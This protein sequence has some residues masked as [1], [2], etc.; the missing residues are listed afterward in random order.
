MINK[1]IAQQNF[2]ASCRLYEEAKGIIKELVNYARSVS[3]DFSYDVSMR[4]FDLVL[5]AVLLR[6]AVEDGYYLDEER[7]FIE[8]ITDYADIMTYFKNKGVNISWESFISLSDSDRKELSLKMVVALDEILTDFI[9]PF[10]IIDKALP[11]DYCTD[12]TNI[13][14]GI[15]IGL[16]R[17]DADSKD[18]DAYKAEGSVAVV[19]IEKVIKEKWNAVMNG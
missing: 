16:A 10:A 9:T 14:G 6:I 3:P 13:I 5:Q 2:D 4:Q 1:E 18:S 19:L 12:L 15:C 8:K 11:R 17:C 7:Q